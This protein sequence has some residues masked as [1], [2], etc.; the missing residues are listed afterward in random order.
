[1]SFAADN[2]AVHRLMALNDLQQNMKAFKRGHDLGAMRELGHRHQQ[3]EQAV[4]QADVARSFGK[5]L[6]YVKGAGPYDN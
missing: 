2:P 3:L 4:L 5:T 6:N 1:M